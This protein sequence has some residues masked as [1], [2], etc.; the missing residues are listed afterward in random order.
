MYNV[1][2]YI[3]LYDNAV[4]PVISESWRFTHMLKTHERPHHFTK[5]GGLGS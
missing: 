2:D 3:I 1:Q 5:S 4:R